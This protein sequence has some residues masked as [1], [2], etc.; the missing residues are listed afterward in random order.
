VRERFEAA[1]RSLEEA[2]A[3]WNEELRRRRELK[4]L[5]NRPPS[6]IL[7]EL[8]AKKREYEARIAAAR[9]EWRAALELLSSAP[10][11][12]KA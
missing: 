5:G 3:L 10:A 4:A 6:A 9:L 2:F 1:R 12:A 7:L 8:Q 11:L